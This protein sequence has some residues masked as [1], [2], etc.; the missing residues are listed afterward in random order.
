MNQFEFAERLGV[1]QSAISQ[2]R[3]KNKISSR[4]IATI[5]AVFPQV[6]KGWLETGKGEMFISDQVE[7]MVADPRGIYQ[8][9]G[10]PELT[11]MAGMMEEVVS[12]GNRTVIDALKQNLVAFRYAVRAGRELENLGVEKPGTS[13]NPPYLDDV[14]SGE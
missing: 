5:C 11:E 8:L 2:I 10:N 14:L 12:S 13:I 6:N 9:P 3:T 7:E 4:M 1:T